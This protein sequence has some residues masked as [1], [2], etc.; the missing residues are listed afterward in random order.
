MADN[1]TP[2]PVHVSNIRDFFTKERSEK[3]VEVPIL[4]PTGEIT[5]GRVF[6]RFSESRS[7]STAKGEILRSYGPLD[8]A[9]PDPKLAPEEAAVVQAEIDVKLRARDLDLA[10]ALVIGWN[11]DEPFTPENV[12]EVLDNMPLLRASVVTTGVNRE[13]FFASKPAP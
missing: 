4:T 10:C 1:T 2:A 7:Y 11:I 9:K 5:D 12:R 13:V 3:G 6:V 8:T